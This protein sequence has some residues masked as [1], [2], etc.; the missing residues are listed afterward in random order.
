MNLAVVSASAAGKNA[1]VDAARELHPPEAV[2]EIKA[3]SAKAIVY[4]DQDYQH[5]V[6]L[7]TEADSIPNQGPAATAVRTLAADNYLAYDVVELD[8]ET[9]KWRVRHIVKPGPT[10]LVTTSTRSLADQLS[11]RVLELGLSDDEQQ[12]R[13]VMHAHARRTE[14][15]FAPLPELAPWHAYGRYVAQRAH[16]LAGISIPFGH[17]LAE[18]VP[19]KAVRMRRDFAQLLM[20]IQANALM[21]IQH[22]A[23]EEGWLVATIGEDYAA[24]RDLLAPLF[25]TLA[26]GGLTPAVRATV[27]AVKPDETNVSQAVIAQ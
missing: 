14:P 26:A 22:R 19:A 7:F 12:T 9:N 27:L 23:I 6:V 1:T 18:L 3:G 4:S 10:G 13:Q 8:P 5:K 21:H 20:T 17:V 2:I 24:A 16:E 15:D 11:T 25:D